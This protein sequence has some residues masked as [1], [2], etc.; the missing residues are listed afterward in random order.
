MLSSTALV[1]VVAALTMVPLAEAQRSGQNAKISI[2]VVTKAETINLQSQAA[3]AGALVGGLVGY[4]TSNKN[5]KGST[6]WGRAA[7][8]AAAGR[9]LG[10]A[11]E[12]DLTGRLY[13]V[14]LGGGTML[15]VVS[16]Q[17]EIQ[18]GDCVIVEEAK[19]QANIRRADP[20]ACQPESA[21]ALASADVQAELQEEAAECVGAKDELLKAE[22]DEQFE[23][24]KR[25]MEI[26]C[27]D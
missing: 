17:K 27:N 10:R 11:A 19:D 6:K 8:G 12:G 16:D 18:Q 20:T 2:G 1:I 3:P 14:D 4:H 13:T 25:K 7:V 26:F 9:A 24:A 23:L 5:S 22:T 21:T 15:Q